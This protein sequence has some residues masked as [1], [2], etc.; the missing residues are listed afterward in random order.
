MQPE[1]DKLVAALEEFYAQEKFLLEKDAG[2]RALTHRLAVYLERQYPAWQVDCDY[3]R[4]G[5]RTLLLPHG[6]I[7]STDDTLGK[8]I[9]PDIVVHQREV[10]KNLLA[11]E[12]RK[13]SNHQS[14]A[15]DQHKLKAMT[16]PHLWFAYWFGVLV[17]LA[18]RSVLACEVYVGGEIDPVLTT[19]LAGGLKD[20]GLGS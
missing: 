12:V 1:L 6:T 11:V 10:P 14:L 13:A 8:S 3:N 5:E 7:I 16:D 19:W 18:R 17:I 2:E 9:Y 15:H 4:L 20:R